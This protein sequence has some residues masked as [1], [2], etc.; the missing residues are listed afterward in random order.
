MTKQEKK[1]R[2][3]LMKLILFCNFSALVFVWFF[4]GVRQAGIPS[5][6]PNLVSISFVAFLFSARFKGFSNHYLF[7]ILCTALVL[8]F[9]HSF[10]RCLASYSDSIGRGFP[11]H[12]YFYAFFG[13]A[14]STLF[15]PAVTATIFWFMGDPQN[16]TKEQR[17]S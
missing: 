7:S 16:G 13:A 5:F 2:F 12:I 1:I 6:S 11:R 10:Y 15:W 3:S 17:L 8:K 9:S 14:N 4:W